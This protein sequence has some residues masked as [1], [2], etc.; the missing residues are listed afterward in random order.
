MNPAAPAGSGNAI[1]DFMLGYP[2]SVNRTTEGIVFGG[3]AIAQHY[4][5]QDDIRVSGTLTLN[6][7]FRY[8]YSPWLKGWGNQLGTFDGK[9]AKPLIIASATNQVDL[10]V[11][12]AAQFA[13]PLYKD[14]IQTS[15]Q[16]GL[17]DYAE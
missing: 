7:G 2:F 15:S 5:V 16:A 10:S 9:S 6:I 12:P 17:P 3:L 4:F 11:Q 14:L 1:G 13:Y 8:E